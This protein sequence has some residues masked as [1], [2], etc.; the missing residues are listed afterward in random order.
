VDRVPVPRDSHEQFVELVG[1]IRREANLASKFG[2]TDR[3]NRL[4]DSLIRVEVQMRAEVL[5]ALGLDVDRI[6]WPAL[7]ERIRQVC[8]PDSPTAAALRGEVKP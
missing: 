7:V 5:K 4:A 2:Q 1:N 3:L 8:Q 6:P